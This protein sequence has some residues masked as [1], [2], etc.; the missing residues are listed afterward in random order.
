MRTL[1]VI[2][3]LLVA[4]CAQAPREA[5]AVACPDGLADSA[6]AVCIALDTTTR[7]AH[8]PRRVYE[9]RRDSAGFA[10]L[11]VPRR[12]THTDGEMTVHVSKAF[13]V[14]GF[15]AGQQLRPNVAL[16]LTSARS[17]GCN[18]VGRMDRC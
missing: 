9:F 11:T 12:A 13:K 5:S 1:K 6:R 2:T 15:W 14:I 7:L 17:C 3:L 10:I 16:P 8:E 4:S 18:A